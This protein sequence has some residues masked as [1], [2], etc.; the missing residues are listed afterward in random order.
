MDWSVVRRPARLCPSR[1][2]GTWLAGASSLLALAGRLQARRSGKARWKHAA[3]WSRTIAGAWWLRRSVH[4]PEDLP[5]LMGREQAGLALRDFDAMTWVEAMS[6][7]LPDDPVLALGQIE[8]T[9]YLRNQ[10]LRDSDWA[11]MDHSVELRTPLVDA[12]LLWQ[13]QPLLAA[14]VRHPGKALLARAP[15]R[16]LPQEIAGRRKTGFGIPVGRWMAGGAEGADSRGWAREVAGV[17]A[18]SCA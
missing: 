18:S 8:S 7:P 14:F 10:L 11:S 17:Y 9:T 6:G 15:A 12:H 2:G 1:P 16:A 13:L 4:A 3:D 5:G